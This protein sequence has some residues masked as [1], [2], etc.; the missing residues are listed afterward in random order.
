MS[1][2]CIYP[3]IGFFLQLKNDIINIY[4]KINDLYQKFYNIPNLNPLNYTNNK[5]II[6]SNGENYILTEFNTNYWIYLN[7]GINYIT[8]PEIN[9]DSNGKWVQLIL[10]NNIVSSYL[11]INNTFLLPS[12]NVY[13][14]SYFV[15]VNNEWR[16]NGFIYDN[17]FT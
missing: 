7:E 8:L 16:P 5:D 9:D 12:F 14:G 17:V 3:N 13:F 10:R 11:V 15:C 2:S 6:I 1:L 4:Q